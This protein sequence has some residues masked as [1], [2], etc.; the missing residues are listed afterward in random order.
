[1]RLFLIHLI[2]LTG[3]HRALFLTVYCFILPV[4]LQAQEADTVL[5]KDVTVTANPISRFGTGARVTTL[6]SAEAFFNKNGSLAQAVTATTPIY[7]KSYGNGMLSTISF[8]GTGASHSSV[9]WNGVNIGYPML[10]QSDLSVLPMFFDQEVALQHGS[11]SSL[12][13]SGAVGGIINLNTKAIENGLRLALT[14]E[15]GSF[16]SFF[17]GGTVAYGADKISF[18]AQAFINSSDNDFPYIN[19][20]KIGAPV[21]RQQHA[22]YSTSGASA[23]ARINL[24]ANSFFS[25]STQL[26]RFDRELQ[27]SMNDQ[28]G[29][30][31]Q[32][33]A[34]FRGMINYQQLSGKTKLDVRYAHLYDQ[35]NFNGSIT[36]ANQNILGLHLTGSLAT[37]LS[38]KVGG[39]YNR[40]VVVSPFF[41]D[42]RAYE[43]RSSLYGALLYSPGRWQMS[44]NFRQT[45]VTGFVVPFTPSL[46]LEYQLIRSRHNL[47]SLKGQAARGYRVPTLNDRYW[48]PG[49]NQDLMPEESFSAE[50]G[51]AGRTGENDW[52]SYEMTVYQ[53][54]VD[55]WI[56]WLPEGSYWSPKNIKQVKGSGVE[57]SAVITHHLG[58]SAV[59]WQ[60]N[61]AFTR[62]VNLTGI[63]QFDRSVGKQL[64]YVPLHN[65]NFSGT[66][67]SRGWTIALIADITGRRFVTADNESDLPGFVLLDANM[68]KSLR[69]KDTSINIYIRLKN[70]LNSSYQNIKNKAMP[71]IS[72]T[73]GVKLNLIKQ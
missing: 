32:T 54:W 56:L 1:M 15:I 70:L 63:D 62:S 21:E 13:G 27:P 3:Y 2:Y 69:V 58:R 10:G 49:G 38:Y 39:G 16:K 4:Q 55:D 61:Y 48:E 72:G 23:D 7:I 71:G 51:V 73:I 26:V 29:G 20:T 33:D 53:M 64:P 46:G 5:L 68:A 30:D 66:L 37:Q 44:A 18:R 17:T 57:L 22:S 42:S 60:T 28:V 35:I 6:D 52:L 9:L 45:F 34:N 67:I 11:G 24:S 25:L 31:N 12:Y 36:E 14:Q 59:K 65:A 47:L 19:T 50:I 8:R 40:I 41:A 43:Q